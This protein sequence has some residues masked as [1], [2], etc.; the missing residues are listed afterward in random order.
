LVDNCNVG[1]EGFDDF[2][3]EAILLDDVLLQFSVDHLETH[4]VVPLCLPLHLHYLPNGVNESMLKL[5]RSLDI[6][7]LLVEKNSLHFALLLL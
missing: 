3:E 7:Y 1:L 4:L 6:L 2:S 5:T